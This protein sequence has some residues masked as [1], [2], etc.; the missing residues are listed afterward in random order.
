MQTEIQQSEKIKKQTEVVQ[1]VKGEFTATQIG[2]VM[3]SLLEEKINFNKVKKLQI[4]EENH[5]SDLA[6]IN[7]RIYQ[8]EGEK[9]KVEEFINAHPQKSFSVNGT[10][11][12]TL[13]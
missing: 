3:S 1:L 9:R 2:E 8:L 5:Q 10:I 7:E 11:E 4:W 13:S 12:I 6:L